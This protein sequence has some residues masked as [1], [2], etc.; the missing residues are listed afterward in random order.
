MTDTDP[1]TAG[2][3]KPASTERPDW[4]RLAMQIEANGWRSLALWLR[5]RTVLMEGEKPYPYRGPLLAPMWVMIVLSALE[6]VA[7]DVIIPWTPG[8]I[9]LRIFLIV[10]GAWGVIFVFGMLAGVTVHPHASGP[11]GL[12]IRNGS[13]LAIR[14]PWEDVPSIR[15]EQKSH[16]GRSV[17]LDGQSLLIAVSKQSTVRV[18]I[19][20]P[21]EVSLLRQGKCLVSA[22]SFYSDDGR[23]LVKDA[24]AWIARTNAA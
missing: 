5:R 2:L 12:L 15:Y 18:E 11:D 24:R 17:Q 21:I 7:L 6:V 22:V 13:S 1:A 10:L 4:F 8:L 3:A 16:D 9:W 20:R 23:A 14:I 19:A